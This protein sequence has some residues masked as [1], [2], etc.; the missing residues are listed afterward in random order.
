MGKTD[1]SRVPAQEIK[2]SLT[3]ISERICMLPEMTREEFRQTLMK[4]DRLQREN[5]GK[6]FKEHPEQLLPGAEIL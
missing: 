1:E 3:A 4:L 5:W 6:H 2:E